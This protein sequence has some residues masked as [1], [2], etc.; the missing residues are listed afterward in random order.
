[1]RI[2]RILKF[3]VL[4]WI[5]YII[6]SALALLVGGM[7]F[8]ATDTFPVREVAIAIAV[9]VFVIY[10]ALLAV[11]SII[12]S[13]LIRKLFIHGRG[14]SA[15]FAGPAKSLA[16]NWYFCRKAPI[17]LGTTLVKHDPWP[18]RQPIGVDD[19]NHLVTIA[20]P[21]SGK[22]T[23]AIWQNLVAHPYP[24]SVF[25]LDPKGEHT[26]NTIK[27]RSKLGATYVLD[28]QGQLADTD[29]PTMRFNP[30]GEIDVNAGDAKERLNEIADACYVS[31]G[32][33]NEHPHFKD[34]CIAMIAGVS[35]H[36]LT[37]PTYPP[38]TH[39]LPGVYDLILRGHVRGRAGPE[40]GEAFERL[41]DEMELNPAI[42]EAP[43]EA[44]RVLRSAGRNEYG[45]IFTTL[46][47]CL[48]WISSENMRQ[49]LLS[50]D[51]RL[52]ALRT[53]VSTVYVVLDFDDMAPEK[54]GRYM[55]VL[56]FLAMSVAR[57]TPLPR[58]RDAAG[59][60]TLFILDEVGMLGSMETIERNYKILRAS[61]VKVW[62]LFQEWKTVETIFKNPDALMASS[63]KQ[64]FGI[65][66]ANTAQLIESYLGKF[67]DIRKSG[68]GGGAGKY[69]QTKQ[70]LDATEI[71]DSLR[72]KAMVQIVI[73]GGGEKF[74]LSRVPYYPTS[75][76]KW[77][78]G[79]QPHVVQARAQEAAPR[80]GR[81]EAVA[82]TLQD[83]L[84][85]YGFE[86]GNYSVEQADV[87]RAQLVENA[88]S[89]QLTQVYEVAHRR[90]VEAA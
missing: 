51:F 73:A 2:F 82:L 8:L 74:E 79:A 80:Q 85:I 59:R 89:E 30:L 57:K 28:P 32:T 52:S 31:T 19:E 1:M 10:T 14:G 16:N 62:S 78:N 27:A 45:S 6:F 81:A 46:I 43:M 17:F 13:S 26:R 24:D 21:G 11:S 20:Q 37:W 67:L 69:E 76:D 5:G 15:R 23:T 86:N 71:T 49:H 22:S 72:Q 48:R 61:K 63:T 77:R 50:S 44:A 36:V 18:F 4:G 34:I 87:R 40:P 60:R 9:A 42:G 75:A 68:T 41:L 56:M 29:I 66:D 25:V 84:E 58:V 64:F 70:L 33:A 65:S 90:L 54:Q 38:S 88:N 55:R 35:A 12:E 7:V 47:R 3:G 83:A 39:N 53:D